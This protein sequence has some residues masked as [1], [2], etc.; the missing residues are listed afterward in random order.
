VSV[1]AVASEGP[2]PPELWASEA[3]EMVKLDDELLFGVSEFLMPDRQ[4]FAFWALY[5]W[6]RRADEIVDGPEAIDEEPATI[7]AALDEFGDTFDKLV[8]G[9]PMAD[10]LDQALAWVLKDYSMAR[11]PFD[12]MLDGMRMDV[13]KTRYDTFEELERYCY[14]VAGTVGLMALPVLGVAKGQESEASRCAKDLGIG[15]QL[16]NIV[17]DV[18]FDASTLSRI[19]LPQEDMAATGATDADFARDIEPSAEARETIKRVSLKAR[20]Y[21]ERGRDGIPYLPMSAVLPVLAIANLFEGIVDALEARDYDSLNAKVRVPTTRKLKLVADAAAA[22]ATEQA[23]RWR[24]DHP[25][26]PLS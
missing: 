22:T 3:A 7:M 25:R 12:D 2:P 17:R 9:E 24:R 23:R 16:V 6:A 18:G 8:A 10:P 20:E 26:W 4:K 11:A 1:R 5:A 21:L 19:Y 14:C 15:I 13:V